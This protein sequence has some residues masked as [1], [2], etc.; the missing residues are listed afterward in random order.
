[1][2]DEYISSEAIIYSQLWDHFNIKKESPVIPVEEEDV[3]S[4]K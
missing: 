3:S 4:R 2:N 1:M